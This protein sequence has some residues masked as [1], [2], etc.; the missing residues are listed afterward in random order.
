MGF[1]GVQVAR[2]VKTND[3]WIRQV[4]SRLL[5]TQRESCTNTART[6]TNRMWTQHT[7]TNRLRV[8]LD[9]VTLLADR[10]QLSQKYMK[11]AKDKQRKAKRKCLGRDFNLRGAGKFGQ[12]AKRGNLG[13]KVWGKIEIKHRNARWKSKK[14]VNESWTDSFECIHTSFHQTQLFARLEKT[15]S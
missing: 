9:S 7:L 11:S 2:S 1:G 12:T 6:W 13:K 10:S 3:T 5:K 14:L 8:T 15:I 4:N